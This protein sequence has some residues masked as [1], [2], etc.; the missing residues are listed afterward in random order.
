MRHERLRLIKRCYSK[1]E[2]RPLGVAFQKEALNRPLLLR[3]NDCGSE[4]SGSSGADEPRLGMNQGDE[5]KRTADDVSRSILDVVET[6]VA[7]FLREQ[8]ARR[9]ITARMTTGI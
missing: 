1:D 5:R 2:G 7:S 9:L 6:G 3:P 4:Q 8:S